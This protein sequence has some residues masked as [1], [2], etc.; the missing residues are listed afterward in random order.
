MATVEK[1]LNGAF[2]ATVSPGSDVY[3]ISFFAKG[4][5]SR[6]Y[7]RIRNTGSADALCGGSAT[8]TEGADGVLLI[9]PQEER[10]YINDPSKKWF[11]LSGNTTCELLVSDIPLFDG[12]PASALAIAR[13]Y[14]YNGLPEDFNDA[15]AALVASKTSISELT[16][17][18]SGKRYGVSGVGG[19]AAALTRLWDAVGLVAAVG[20]DTPNA[21]YYNSFDS[22]P[23]F[24]RRKCVG[25]WGAPVNGKSAFAVQS[26][27][28]DPDFAED[29]TK[30]DYVA[31]EIDPLWYYQDLDAGII[32]VS[33]SYYPGWKPHPV[34]LDAS[35][36]IREKTYLPC[37]NLAIKD[38]KAV[39]LPG[40]EP[41][42]GGYKTLWDLARTYNSAAILE[43]M[44]VR[45]YEWLLST[46]EFATQNAQSIMSG[47]SNMAY[48]NTTTY[49]ATVA[50]TGADGANKFV[51]A[52]AGAD[53]YVVGQQL[54][55]GDAAYAE[56]YKRKILSIDVYDAGNK[57]LT[58]DG[59]ALDIPVGYWSSSRAWYTGACNTVK[60]PSGSPISNSTGKY[61]ARYRYRENVWGNI[62]STC[63][64]LFD[65]RDGDGGATPYTISWYK[66]VDPAW[67][68]TSAS[69]PEAADLASAAFVKLGVATE[70]VDGCIKKIAADARYP[71]A[72]VPVMQTGGSAST[73]FCDYGYIVSSNVIRSVRLGGYAY[74]GTSAGPLCF[75]ADSAP[76]YARWYCG[77]GLYVTQ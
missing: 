45:H 44:A 17:I 74:F 12:A 2:H 13:A 30:G 4:G 55:M 59:A 20:T 54:A 14:G 67:Y 51:L 39:S 56:T 60:T 11:Y 29:G 32:G 61:P 9:P 19:S 22:L 62:N 40:Y 65:V 77:A 26:Y 15:L 21:A 47:A 58:F 25:T 50:T 49:Q 76:S 69:K 35:G 66:L 38:G 16:S 53:A 24:N 41:S 57:A 10:Q 7:V 63:G 71:E 6:N 36:N 34:C 5:A 43:P 3:K 33:A 46:I 42:S 37:Y 23:P 68:P 73:F 48:S 64:D 8:L 27:Y 28:G 31:V 75:F 70:Y 1:N 18:V 52:N 72:I